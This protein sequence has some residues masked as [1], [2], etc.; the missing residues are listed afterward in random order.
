MSKLIEFIEYLDD[1]GRSPF[2]K[3]MNDLDSY[4]AIKV[5]VAMTKVEVGNFS[6][7]RNL[8]G[9]ISEIKIDFGPGYRVYFA[10][11]KEFLL[12]LLG[13]GSKKNQ[14]HEIDEAKAVW[15]EYKKRKRSI[16]ISGGD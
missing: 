5:Q 13:G 7:V 12:L 11:E 9:G 2:A 15:K 16:L 8:G 14:Q 6:S 10:K 1:F 3:W 4:A